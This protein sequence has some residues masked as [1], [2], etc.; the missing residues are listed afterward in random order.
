MA[1]MSD[2]PS[3]VVLPTI[4]C[5]MG[6]LGFD[7]KKM[8][9]LYFT[10]SPSTSSRVL[11]SGISSSGNMSTPLAEARTMKSCN[12]MRRLMYRCWSMK[13]ETKG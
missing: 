4:C 2:K 10:H 12:M 7:L 1:S 5:G 11:L 6:T 8:T 9:P 3:C 13:S